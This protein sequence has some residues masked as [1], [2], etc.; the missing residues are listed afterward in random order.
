MTAYTTAESI[1]GT[2][3][4]SASDGIV[5]YLAVPYAAPPAGPLRF[6]APQNAA[7]SFFGLDMVAVTGAEWRRGDDY[8]TLNSWAPTSAENRPVMVYIHGGG[9]VLGTKD[10]A[11]YDGRNF[12]RDGVVAVIL[13]S[14][15]TSTASA[16][17]I[18]RA[19]WRP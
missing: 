9:L 10:A 6:A 12:A 4:G 11:A 8:L 3:R 17:S 7:A 19:P 1:S 14:P 18:R 13:R 5:T 16:P 2:V 15:P